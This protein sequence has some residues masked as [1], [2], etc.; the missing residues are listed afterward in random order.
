MPTLTWLERGD[1][2][3]TLCAMQICQRLTWLVGG[4]GAGAIVHA[5]HARGLA[6]GVVAGQPLAAVEA[7]VLPLGGQVHL[8]LLQEPACARRRAVVAD[9]QQRVTPCQHPSMH[10]LPQ[11]SVWVK[12]GHARTTSYLR[13]T[14]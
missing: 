4:D 9:L 1:V 12:L 8:H 2:A 6:V 3:G 10:C 5:E 11:R 14:R 13:V 7:V